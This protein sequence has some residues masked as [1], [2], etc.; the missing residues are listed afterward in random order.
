MQIVSEKG[1]K[2][3][4]KRSPSL[5]SVMR[6]FLSVTVQFL[7]HYYYYYY[8]YRPTKMACLFDGG[9]IKIIIC[10]RLLRKQ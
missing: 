5:E 3:N 9:F 2:N 10:I 8:Y 7:L 4:S 1:A 6:I